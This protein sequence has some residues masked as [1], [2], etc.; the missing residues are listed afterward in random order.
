MCPYRKQD[1]LIH[2]DD[3]GATES[4]TR[5]IVSAWTSGVLDGFSILANGQATDMLATGLANNAH[6]PARLSAHLNLSEGSSS[7]PPSEL[8][9]LTDEEGCL[10]HTF[11]SLHISLLFS[12]GARRK[13]ILHQIERE[14]RAQ[15]QAILRVSGTRKIS[16]IDGHIH[17]HMLPWTFAIACKLA[18]EFGIEEIRISREPFFINSLRDLFLPYYLVN[19]IKHLVLN[20]CSLFAIKIARSFGMKY[21]SRIVGVLYSGHMTAARALCGIDKIRDNGR[22]ELVFHVGQALAAEKSRWVNRESI[23]DFYLSDLRSVELFE[24]TQL[25]NILLSGNSGEC[26]PP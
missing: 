11:F 16:A 1:V 24:A 3:A 12:T 19:I 18:R 22:I 14:W 15:I 6:R 10:K 5:D 21:P 4:V 26:A 9:Q 25:R 13:S 8:P 2:S 7:A 20:T 23:A 17:V